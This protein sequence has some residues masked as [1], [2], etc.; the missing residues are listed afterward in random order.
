MQFPVLGGR[1]PGKFQK[2][3]VKGGGVLKAHQ[4]CD[5]SQAQLRTGTD[6][7]LRLGDALP[8]NVLPQG[9]TCKLWEHRTEGRTRQ[10]ELPG[11]RGQRQ[12]LPVVL[13]DKADALQQG[14]VIIGQFFQPMC[15]LG[16]LIVTLA[17]M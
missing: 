14:V 3:S 2:V 10:T 5:L 12:R 6:Q 11:K 15:V 1:H 17:I 13:I 9:K 7:H 16:L 4:S 8:G